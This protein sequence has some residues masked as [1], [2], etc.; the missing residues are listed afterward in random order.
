[1]EKNDCNKKCDDFYKFV[2]KYMN[3]NKS[4]KSDYCA[5][6]KIETE[7]C[8]KRCKEEVEFNQTTR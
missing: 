4:T 2:L 1:M 5:Q 7:K 6:A 3:G 8:R